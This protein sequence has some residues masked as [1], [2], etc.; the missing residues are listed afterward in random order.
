M[1]HENEQKI[2][3]GER[4]LAFKE[5]HRFTWAEI[6][7]DLMVSPSFIHSV[8][9]GEKRLGRDASDRLSLLE[10]GMATSGSSSG[11]PAAADAI[12]EPGL[13]SPPKNTG[14][15]MGHIV[16]LEDQL[17]Y[18]RTKEDRL[19]KIIEALA[20]KAQDHSYDAS[21]P[22]AVAASGARYSTSENKTNKKGA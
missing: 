13:Y 2:S 21:G 9:R 11:S 17:S 20:S 12:R 19:L 8:K 18:A 7:R 3:D 6:A 1:Q 4:L 5:T 22:P 14:E 10:L 16:W 15:I